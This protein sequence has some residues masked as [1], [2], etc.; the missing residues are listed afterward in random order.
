MND[1]HPSEEGIA[2][3]AQEYCCPSCER[4]GDLF[5][6]KFKKVIRYNCTDLEVELE[7]HEC[8]TCREMVFFPEEIK[9]NE[10]VVQD[11]KIDY[12]LSLEDDL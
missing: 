9:R 6:V 10:Q 12:D 7:G 11:A 5:P 4:R 1:K 8:C 3:Y 2:S